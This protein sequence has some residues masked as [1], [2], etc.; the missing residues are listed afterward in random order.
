MKFTIPKYVAALLGRSRWAVH[1]ACFCRADD[2]SYTIILP[3]RTCFTQARTLKAE[4]DSLVAWGRRVMGPE[5][6]WERFPLVIVRDIPEE[7]HY[8]FQFA[9]VTIYDPIMMRVEHL[10]GLD[11]YTANS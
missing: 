5:Y 11:L 10:V 9:R 3:K 1:S 4:C 8:R 2:P 7:T 6:D